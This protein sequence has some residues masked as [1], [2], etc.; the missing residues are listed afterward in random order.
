MPI[1][2]PSLIHYQ[3][4]LVEDSE[5]EEE[6]SQISA[7]NLNLFILLGLTLRRPY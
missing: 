2:T 6:Y 3:A 4:P 5:E 7:A 1:Q